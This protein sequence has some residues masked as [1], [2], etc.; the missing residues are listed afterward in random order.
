MTIICRPT[1]IPSPR[2]ASLRFRRDYHHRLLGRL[3]RHLSV[4][5]FLLRVAEQEEGADSRGT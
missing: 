5:S 3:F 1:N 4:Y 2:C